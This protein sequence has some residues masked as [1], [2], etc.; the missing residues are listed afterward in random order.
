MSLVCFYGE[1]YCLFFT[2]FVIKV[3]VPMDS[4]YTVK[5]K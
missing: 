3:D 4:Y 1:M 5:D 2:L